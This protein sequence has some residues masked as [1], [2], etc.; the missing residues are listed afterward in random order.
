MMVPAPGLFSMITETP[1]SL[2][3]SCANVRATTSVPPPGA[4]GTTIRMAR[5]GYK[6]FASPVA[7][8]ASNSAANAN[9]NREVFIGCPKSM[10]FAGAGR[11][12]NTLADFASAQCRA[13]GDC[14][15]TSP[16]GRGRH[17]GHRSVERLHPGSAGEIDVDL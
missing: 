14:F 17:A 12:K 4:K 5:S 10:S 7:N 13:L 8:A 6:A 15:F 9:G 2:A 11:L 3:I 1:K 16:F